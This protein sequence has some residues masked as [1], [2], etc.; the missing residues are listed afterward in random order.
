MIQTIKPTSKGTKWI[1]TILGIINSIFGAC[2]L[3]QPEVIATW[4]LMQGVI[5]VIVGPLALV[6]GVILFIEAKN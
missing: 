2:Q 1:F 5:L 3:M 6:Y 4:G